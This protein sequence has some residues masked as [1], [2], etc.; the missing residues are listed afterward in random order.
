MLKNFK[1]VRFIEK[2][3]KDV[4]R[5]DELL[6]KFS[7]RIKKVDWAEFTII[8]E[9]HNDYEESLNLYYML[10]YAKVRTFETSEIK[11]AL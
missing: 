6:A 2:F 1:Y 4:G 7:E 8:M 11:D 3:R 5:K 10:E 9:P